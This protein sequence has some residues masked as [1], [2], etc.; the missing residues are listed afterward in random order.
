MIQ[1]GGLPYL[2]ARPALITGSD[3]PESRP[4]EQGAAL[5]MD[6]VLTGLR[7][8]GFGKI[9]KQYASMSATTLG[10]ALVQHALD[11]EPNQILA[12][13]DLRTLPQV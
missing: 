11:G 13:Q 1:N 3:R 2:I 8:I 12:P 5:I 9:C 7:W 10:T 4:L 6:G